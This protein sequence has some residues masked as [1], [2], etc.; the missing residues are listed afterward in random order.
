VVKPALER[1]DGVG[2]VELA[3]TGLPEI[4]ISLDEQRCA[5]RGLEP[6]MVA[7]QLAEQD[8]LFPAGSIIEGGREILLTIDGRYGS[9]EAL[10]GTPILLPNGTLTALEELGDIEERE[11]ESES[12]DG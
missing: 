2:E 3:G 12:W 6:W 1:I 11:R 8:A 5:A 4:V 9:V 7:Q 10:R